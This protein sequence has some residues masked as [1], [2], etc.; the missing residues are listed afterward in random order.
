M[1]QIT[2]G[3]MRF[4]TAAG[5]PLVAA[6]DGG[7]LTSDGGLPWL[8]E[9]DGALGLSAAL[10][11][12]IPEWRQGRVQHSLVTLVRQRL[13]QIACGY[14]DQDDTDA[15]PH[16]RLRQRRGTA[17]PPGGEWIARTPAQAA[18]LTDHRWSL[19]ELLTFPAPPPPVTRRGRRPHWLQEVAHAT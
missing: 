19:Y 2:T 3:R 16:D 18:G 14:A 1:S 10:A 12:C 5:L 11:H 9:A 4:E 7:R 15:L 17:D 13:F 8:A 6:F